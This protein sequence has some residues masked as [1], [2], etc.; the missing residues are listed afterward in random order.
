MQRLYRR[1]IT[2][3][4]S[5]GAACGRRPRPHAHTHRTDRGRNTGGRIQTGK[6]KTHSHKG[7]GRAAMRRS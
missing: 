7:E 5:P 4:D 1:L 6:H 2:R 3:V